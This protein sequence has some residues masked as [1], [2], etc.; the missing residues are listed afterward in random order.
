MADEV[1]PNEPV[2]E[3]GQPS[4]STAAAEATP[5]PERSDLEAKVTAGLNKLQDLGDPEPAAEKPAKTPAKEPETEAKSEPEA[6]AETGPEEDEEAGDES[7]TDDDSQTEVEDSEEDA[8]APKTMTV[9]AAYR[10]SLQAYGWTDDEIDAGHATSPEKFMQMA[11]RIHGSRNT[12]TA[13]WAEIGRSLRS[14]NTDD[15]PQGNQPVQ[16]ANVQQGFAPVDVDGLV[17]KYGN[18]ELVKELANPV[19]QVIERINAILPT[20][21]TGVQS[22]RE[23]QTKNL[24]SQIDQFFGQTEMAPFKEV[25]GAETAKLTDNQLQTRSKV[26]EMA[27]ALIAGARHQGR[28]LDVV[29]ALTLAHDAVSGSLKTEAVRKEL[30]G[31]VETRN[32]GLSLR[33][34]KGGQKPNNGPPVDRIELENRTR[35]RLA[36]AFSL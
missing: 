29:Q 14:P 18:E 2:T 34:A 25:Y 20:L 30:R 7:E 13:E 3:I 15:K 33:P 16:K 27:D 19:N 36:A 32:K 1:T 12:Q 35:N 4:A 22:I 28:N 31:K 23:T 9:P 8:A 17:E 6:D 24:A 11:E 5:T 21:M 26:L 10:R